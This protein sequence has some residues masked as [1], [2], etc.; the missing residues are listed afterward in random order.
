MFN[1]NRKQ[2]NWIIIIIVITI[3]WLRWPSEELMEDAPP[4]PLTL[5]I[6]EFQIWSTEEQV[7]VLRIDV[8]NQPMLTASIQTLG[9]AKDKQHILYHGSDMD[10]AVS[11]VAK[12]LNAE[13]P[14]Y[15]QPSQVIFYGPWSEPVAKL[16]AAKMIKSLALQPSMMCLASAG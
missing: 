13:H 16:L 4:P 15:Q 14:A 5:I 9:Q 11:T 8:Q 3:V 6:P 10:Q 7:P 1:F 2:L 12:I